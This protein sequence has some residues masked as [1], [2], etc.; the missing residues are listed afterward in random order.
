MTLPIET[1]GVIATVLA[2]VGVLANNRRMRWCFLIWG[3]S[4]TLSAI[5]HAEAA[6]WSLFLRDVVFLI[7]AFEGW[8][9]WGRK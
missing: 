7:L 6:I 5:I 2:V 8:W 3:V 4:N 9:R 1:I